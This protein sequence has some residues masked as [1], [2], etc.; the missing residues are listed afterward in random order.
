MRNRISVLSDNQRNELRVENFI[1]HVI[2]AGEIEPEYLDEVVLSSDSQR[3][4][5]RGIIAETGQ[6]TQYVFI[7][8]AL[9]PLAGLCTTATNEPDTR[10]NSV[11]RDIASLFLS[12]H[13]AGRTS[14]GVLII[15][16]V[17]IPIGLERKSLIALI[18]LDYTPVLRQKRLEPEGVIA[19]VELEEILEALSENK[20]SVQKRALIDLDNNFDWNILAIERKKTGAVL[21]S[22]DAITDYFQSFLSVKLRENNSTLTKRVIKECHRW[23][24]NYDGD[25]EGMT[26][27]DIRHKAISVIEVFSN[28]EMSY[29]DF[30]ERICLHHDV[31]QASRMSAS[32]DAHMTEV[33]LRGVSFTPKPNSISTSERKRQWETDSGIKILWSGERNPTVLRKERQSDGSFLI[34]IKAND[35]VESE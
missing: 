26:A 29:N 2:K 19:R 11:S 22:D 6:G 25:L 9:S 1:Y 21:D 32:F 28:S 17:T 16:R 13:T 18:K 35:V 20:A 31:E 24:K 30:K 33:G 7:D 8:R 10:F 4:F 15:A 5:F 14:D 23:A 12:Y 3:E 34:T 27:G